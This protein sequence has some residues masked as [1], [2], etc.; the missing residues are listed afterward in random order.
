[1]FDT[2]ILP[3]FSHAHHYVPD[4]EITFDWHFGRQWL[5]WSPHSPLDCFVITHDEADWMSIASTLSLL[6]FVFCVLSEKAQFETETRLSDRQLSFG[7]VLVGLVNMQEFVV[8][9]KN[10]VHVTICKTTRDDSKDHSTFLQIHTTLLSFFSA[11]RRLSFSNA[12]SQSSTV[13]WH[14]LASTRCDSKFPP[15]TATLVFLVVLLPTCS[16]LV[17]VVVE[18][19]TARCF[20]HNWCAYVYIYTR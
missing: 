11:Y 4:W 19:Q 15:K 17:V 20:I 16:S 3:P 2:L 12:E 8:W 9:Q 6:C 18:S 13:Y 1:M 14:T 5:N 7:T 10:L